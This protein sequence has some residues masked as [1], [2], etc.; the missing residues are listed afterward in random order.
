MY[1]IQQRGIIL[2]YYLSKSDYKVA[3]DCASKL[4]YKKKCYPTLD[5]ENEYLQHL[6]KG[7][8]MVG[9]LATLLYPNGME[10]DTGSNHQEAINKTR[11]L[12]QNEDVTLFE[13]AI[14]SNGKLIRI[15]ILEK[16]GNKVNL[17][18]VK[19]K[20]YETTTDVKKT[21][22]IEKDL[23]DYI[24]DVAFQYYVLKEAYHDWEITPYLLLPD[25]AKNTKVDKLTS[26]F[27]ITDVSPVNSKFRKYNVVFSGSLDEIR[28]DNLLTKV[29]VKK[30]VLELQESIIKESETF[31]Q[32]LTDDIKKI[33][34]EL[35]KDCFKCEYKLTDKDHPIS[36]YQ[37]CWK[38]FPTVDNHISDL[39]YIGSIG[40]YRNPLANQLINEKKLSL[41][42]FPLSNLGDGK[43]AIRQKIQIKHTLENSE[44]IAKELKSSLLS[45]PYP[46]YFID[47][48]TTSTALP[49]HIGMRPYETINF[50]WSCHIIEK[51]GTTPI[52]KEW[53]DLE[54][55]FPSFRFAESL[56]KTIGTKGTFFIWSQYENTM[57]RTIYEQCHKYGYSNKELLDWLETMVRFNKGDEEVFYDLNK[58][59]ISS[60]FHP[61]MKG[62]TS[63][64]WTLPAVLNSYKSPEIETL[65]KTFENNLSLYA[66]DN[67]GDVIDPYKLLPQ[68]DI[69]NKAETIK[70]GTGAMRAY[71]DIM[72]GLKKGNIEELEKY[73]TALL[74]YCKLDTLAMVI[75][76]KHWTY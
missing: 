4:F 21:K 17:I 33:P 6:A 56:M 16:T 52:H 64:K 5:E 35:T 72:Y 47:F 39:Y 65:L 50:Q 31:L 67:N 63:I 26:S 40:G 49:L 18:E 76:W 36:G 62:K 30:R 8:Y 69:Y 9:K 37:E 11:D 13:A 19:S 51:P 55:S 25:K 70:D 53:I 68:I 32:S 71:E 23:D 15:D 20:S 44:W 73:K 66:K 34:N 7:G 1:I 54:P 42:D 45:L 60:Y 61:Q 12:L 22:Q 14:E 38:D 28:N 24:L 46:L 10:I 43:Q 29:D 41:Q 27:S 59:A 48:E 58:T 2:K 57:L 75:I 3:H 74:R